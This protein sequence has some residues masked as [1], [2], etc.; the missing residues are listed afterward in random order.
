MILFKSPEIPGSS[1]HSYLSIS[2]FSLEFASDKEDIRNLLGGPEEQSF[3]KK[4][5]SFQTILSLVY[6]LIPVYILYFASIFHLGYTEVKLR[7]FWK[8]LF[9]FL[10]FFSAFFIIIKNLKLNSVLEAKSVILLEESLLNTK[11][12]SLVSWLFIYAA[13]GVTGLVLWLCNSSYL[14]KISGLIFFTAFTLSLL[15]F[16]KLHLLEISYFLLLIGFFMVF[17]DMIHRAYLAVGK[18]M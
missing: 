7:F 1:K 2:Y 9:Y 14:F 11:E 8:V 12:I 3:Y 17:V 18:W 5:K 10:L 16:Y 6:Y 13:S 15:G 4:K